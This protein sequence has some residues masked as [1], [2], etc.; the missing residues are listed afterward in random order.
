MVYLIAKASIA[1]ARTYHQV[2]A[3]V[4]VGFWPMMK[5]MW[6]LLPVNLICGYL[7]L[8]KS[9]WAPACN[10]MSFLVG[11]YANT[12]TKKRRLAALRKKHFGD[13]RSSPAGSRA[14]SMSPAPNRD[15]SASDSELT[16]WL[17]NAHHEY[18]VESRSPASDSKLAV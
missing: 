4:L 17:K 15:P 1:G 11:T 10:I 18:S 5:V 13:Y 14:S 6:I 9:V 16:I 12:L 3:T 2:R 7:F 8:P